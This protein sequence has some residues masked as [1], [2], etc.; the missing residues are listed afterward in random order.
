MTHKIFS[1]S[2]V[3]LLVAAAW[4]AWNDY[5]RDWKKYQRRYNDLVAQR[6]DPKLRQAVRPEKLEVKQIVVNQLHRVDRCVTC[7]VAYDNPAF[8]KDQEPLR[9]HTTSILKSHPVEKYGCT[10]CHG[11]QGT[12]TTYEG[13][14]HEEL[15]SWEESMWKGD[16]IQSACGNC[17]K[18]TNVP[19]A[20]TLSIARV[21]FKEQFSCDACHQ[22]DG[23]GASDA[24]DLSHIGSKPLHAFDFSHVEGKRSKIRWFLEHFKNPQV[25]VPGSGMPPID[26]TD[27]QAK[28]MTILLLGL[29][30]NKLPKEYIVVAR[31]SPQ[32]GASAA[33]LMDGSRLLEEKHCLLCHTLS[34]R[35]GKVGPELSQVAARRNADWLFQH[36]K[37]PR[38]IVPGSKMP[39]LHLTDEEAN[40]LTRYMLALNIQQPV[41]P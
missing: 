23:V 14:A 20:P 12:A 5:N 25:V 30:D 7:H 32:S 26:M 2:S 29:T 8:S 41:R 22:V 35:G 37:N 1:I 4:G 40:D 18:E 39:D 3:L 10:I 31:N 16:Y 11:G 9:Q 21:L 24:P 27:D 19:G 33:T 34:G 6:L 13:A 15:E 38:S 28:A 36:F 17:H